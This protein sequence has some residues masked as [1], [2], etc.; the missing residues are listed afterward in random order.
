MEL[1][2]IVLTALPFNLAST[3]WTSKGSGHFPICVKK[4]K[5]DLEFVAP[6]HDVTAN[7]VPQVKQGIPPA[8]PAP[9]AK[10]KM[11]NPEDHIP[12]KSKGGLS[13]N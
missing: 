9:D 11:T 1:C 7:L 10:V 3:F 2:N 4:V 6:T 5:E 8:T 13:K 12:K